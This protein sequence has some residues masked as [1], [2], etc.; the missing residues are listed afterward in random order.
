MNKSSSSRQHTKM[1]R[2]ISWN[3]LY[4]KYEEK[5]NPRSQILKT[6]PK[7][8]DR[9]TAIV[10]KL[11]ANVNSNTVICLQ[12]AST[13]LINVVATVFATT[14]QIFATKIRDNEH[15]VTV[16]PVN[17]T[18]NCTYWSHG[19]SNGYIAIQSDLY[20]IV[21]CHLLPQRYAKSSVMEYLNEYE[22]N[23]K[24]VFIV[25]D[26][27]EKHNKIR[28]SLQTRFVCP[29]YGKTYKKKPID[30][31]IFDVTDKTCKYTPT[32][33][34]QTNLSDHHAIMLDLK[35]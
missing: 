1:L 25:G 28:N 24:N 31:I 2:V 7:E 29:Y 20:H 18:V 34:T 11:K 32:L 27:N 23:N 17:I 6:Y 30:H 12:E 15:L 22:S 4:R 33:I 16:V 26:F 8:I 13:N 19:T 21:N 9:V 5:Y 14:H 3:V 35:L 10:S